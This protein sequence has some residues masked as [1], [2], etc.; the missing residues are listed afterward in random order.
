MQKW[1]SKYIAWTRIFPNG[2]ETEPNE[3]GLEFYDKILDLC[4]E[5]DIEPLVTLSHFEIPMGLV[6][7]YQ[8]FSDPKVIDFFVNYA[9]TVMTR[10]KDKVKY[11][12]TFN[13]INFGLL[14][15]GKFITLRIYDENPEEETSEKKDQQFNALHNVFLANAKTVIEGKKINPDFKIGNM[16]A[17]LTFYPLSPHPLDLLR[18]QE[19]DQ[20]I[21]NYCGDVQVKGEYSYFAKNYLERNNIN[22]EIT[23]EDAKILKEGTVDFYTFSYYMTNCVSHEAGKEM[24]AGNLMGALKIHS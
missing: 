15:F 23:K 21:N 1:D 13:E 17:H 18:V 11:W 10:Y 12:L 24:T 7:K 8:G 6:K 4:L 20:F 22:L 3:K 19:F 16:I 5:N 2:D 14:P 9:T